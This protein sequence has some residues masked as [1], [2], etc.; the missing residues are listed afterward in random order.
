MD[1][2]FCRGSAE[3]ERHETLRSLLGNPATRALLPALAAAC[4]LAAAPARADDPTADGATA[5]TADGAAAATGDTATPSPEHLMSKPEWLGLRIGAGL[6]GPIAQLDLATLRWR[7]FYWTVI[8][9]GFLFGVWGPYYGMWG[10]PAFWGATAAG[11]PFHLGADGVHEIRLGLGLGWGLGEG[12]TASVSGFAPEFE[13][14]YHK[15]LREHLGVVV[16]LH[17]LVF[18]APGTDNENE[19]YRAPPELSLVFGITI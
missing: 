17:L 8:R 15:N 11:V 3:A 13:I 18:V 19:P 1:D 16:A 14:A 7:H 6:A 5:A 10:G 2:S 9:S 12:S 4:L